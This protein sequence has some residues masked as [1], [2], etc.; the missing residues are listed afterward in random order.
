MKD[1]IRFSY[2]LYLYKYNTSG[3]LDDKIAEYQISGD[4]IEDLQKKLVELKA[5]I[6]I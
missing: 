1:N 5:V 4:T 6:K 2:N 3:V